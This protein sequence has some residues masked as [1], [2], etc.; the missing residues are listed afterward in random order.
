MFVGGLQEMAGVNVIFRCVEP[1]EV[2][3]TWE[4]IVT[5]DVTNLVNN[6]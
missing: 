1:V 2:A 6:Q 4:T 5:E 3:T